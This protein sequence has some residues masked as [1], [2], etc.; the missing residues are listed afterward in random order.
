MQRIVTTI[1]ISVLVVWASVC[2]AQQTSSTAIPNF[3]RYGGAL[4]DAQG[5]VLSS[6]TV[7]VT[8]AIYKQQDGGAALWLELVADL[9]SRLGG[10][11]SSRS[12]QQVQGS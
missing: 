10:S 5:V 3:I 4:N 2:P 7:G 11:D 8:F 9:Q 6:A 1:A 12:E